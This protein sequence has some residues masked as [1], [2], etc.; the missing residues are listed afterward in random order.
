M[1]PGSEVKTA[2]LAGTLSKDLESKNP[3]PGAWMLQVIP[4]NIQDQPLDCSKHSGGLLEAVGT[5]LLCQARFLVQGLGEALTGCSLCGGHPRSW[6]NY[7]AYD[8]ALG[9]QLPSPRP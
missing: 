2:H 4:G 5:G 1:T 7:Q 9:P 3:Q 6:T 8:T